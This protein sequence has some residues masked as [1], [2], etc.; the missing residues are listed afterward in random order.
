MNAYGDCFNLDRNID[1]RVFRYLFQIDV[2][3]DTTK[4]IF[5]RSEADYLTICISM[6]RK[7]NFSQ[8]VWNLENFNAQEIPTK[9]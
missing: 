8:E 7:T 2:I 1:Q 3:E 6:S 4:G 5:R 9:V